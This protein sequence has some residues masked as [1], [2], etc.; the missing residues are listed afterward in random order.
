[1]NLLTGKTKTFKVVDYHTV[2]KVI[3]EEMPQLSRPYECVSEEEWSNDSCYIV[4]VDGELS[5]YEMK[6][7]REML[8]TGKIKAY[9]TR[10]ILN[11]LCQHEKIDKGEYLIQ[12]SW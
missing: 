12:V 8:T 5:D 2:D 11:Y 1:M 10:T 4:D 7:I 6:D 9:R 3:N